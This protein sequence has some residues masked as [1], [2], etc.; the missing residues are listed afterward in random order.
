MNVFDQSEGTSRMHAL[1]ILFM[2]GK[3]KLRNVCVNARKKAKGDCL[4]GFAYYFAFDNVKGCAIVG[5][6]TKYL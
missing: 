4:I 3:K 1:K 5:C 2:Q 6:V